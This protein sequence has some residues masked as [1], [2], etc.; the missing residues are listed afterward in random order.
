MDEEKI[1]FEAIMDVGPIVISHTKN[2]VQEEVPSF[3][4]RV[5]RLNILCLIPLLII[6]GALFWR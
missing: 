2:T 5:L 1:R 6:L 4:R 3:L